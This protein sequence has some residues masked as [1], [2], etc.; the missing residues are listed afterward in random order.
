[1][2]PVSWASIRRSPIV[3]SRALP[4]TATSIVA[5]VA[6]VG[7]AASLQAHV[8]GSEREYLSRPIELAPRTKIVAYELDSRRKRRGEEL[9]V[10]LY[11]EGLPPRKIPLRVTPTG[12]DPSGE[13]TPDISRSR[14]DA[15]PLHRLRISIRIP[16]YWNPGGYSIRVAG[17][18]RTF[19][20][21]ELLRSR[22]GAS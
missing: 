18:E 14:L 20:Q 22:Q 1:M 11:F 6:L 5:A 9:S 8:S 15:A 17:H 3:V 10:L 7:L 12:F 21:F 13:R 19:G 16:S 2:K 4:R